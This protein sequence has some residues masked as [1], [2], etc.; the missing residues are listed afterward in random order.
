MAGSNNFVL[1]VNGT[2]DWYLFHARRNKLKRV[3]FGISLDLH[4][5]CNRDYTIFATEKAAIKREKTRKDFGIFRAE[6]VSNEVQKRKTTTIM[7]ITTRTFTD[8]EWTE[9]EQF[10][11]MFRA[12]KQRKQEWQKKMGVVL[13]EKAEKIRKRRAEIDKLFEEK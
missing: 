4:Y 13:A 7:E 9:H 5:L 11:Q 8:E 1:S 10:V 6:A 12:A 2:G 3:L